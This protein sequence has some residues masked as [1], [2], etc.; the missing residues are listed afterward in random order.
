MSTLLMRLVNPWLRPIWLSGK[1][2]MEPALPLLGTVLLAVLLIESRQVPISLEFMGRSGLSL[3]PYLLTSVALAAWVKAAGLE[4]LIARVFQ[5]RMTAMITA[6]ALFG[7]AAPLCSCGVIPLIAALLSLGVPLAPVMAFWL[8]SPVMAPDMFVLT[9]AELG[10]GFA[11][12]KTLSAVGI[13]ILGAVVTLGFHNAGLLPDPL[14]ER[15]SAAAARKEVSVRWAV[16]TEPAR[17]Q[18]FVDEA[19]RAG[20][21]LVQW[22]LLAF[23]LESLMVAWLPAEA[24]VPWVGQQ[25]WGGIWL[26][27]LLGVPL[28]LNGYAA[29]PLVGG[30]MQS[31]MG[32]GSAMAFMTAGAMT[33]IP[34]MIAVYALVR[35][36]VFALY[37]AMSMVGAVLAGLLYQWAVT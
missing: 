26:S 28:Y 15:R 11:I 5:G 24:I 12:G 8:A 14:R 29:I 10:T 33:S 23:F 30:L 22:L 7:T 4:T 36:R 31:G 6:A 3:A 32:P 16:W 20:M 21:F 35:T 17:R 2:K 34:A 1:I 25:E 37:I 13:G 9:A 27:A 19:W 18:A